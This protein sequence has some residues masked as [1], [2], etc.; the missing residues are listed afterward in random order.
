MRF[1]RFVPLLPKV[2]AS[3][4]QPRW[5]VLID[6]VVYALEQPPS[7]SMSKDEGLAASL[8][9]PGVR[10]DQVQL[11]APAEPSKIICVGRNYAEHAAELG[12]ETPDEPLLFFKPPSS[13]IGPGGDVVHPTISQRVDHEAEIA[14]VIGKRCRHLTEANAG[15][16]IFGYTLAND[17]TARDIQ[18]G[19]SQWT[20][21]KGFDTFCAL[22]PWI[23]TDFDPSNRT[24]RCLVNDELRQSSNT[25][26]MIFS[27]AA[28]LVYITRVMTL[29]PGD[30]VLTGTPAGVAPVQPGDV[31]TVEVDGLGALSNPV[32]GEELPTA[33]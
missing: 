11:L 1:V 20:R 14:V 29:E 25:N 30:L 28:I 15:S 19:D 13:L 32:V 22:G 8:A 5:G 31:M 3:W 9:G 16:A 18:K 17:V 6:D 27:I 24:V 10:L 26:L 4:L 2:P 23:D 21:G 7:F 33:G 12:N